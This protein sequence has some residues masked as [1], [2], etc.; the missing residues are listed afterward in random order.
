MHVARLAVDTGAQINA[1]GL[2]VYK[3]QL[4][5]Y[6]YLDAFSQDGRPFWETTARRTLDYV[7][8]EL[9]SPEGAF[10]CGQDAD[11]G[12]EELSLIHI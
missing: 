1:K 2:D 6:A 9:T 7:L 10:Y 4:L 12:G 3:R 5:A 11:S 8:R